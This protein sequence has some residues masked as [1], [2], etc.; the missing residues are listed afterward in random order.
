MCVIIICVFVCVFCGIGQ[1]LSSRIFAGWMTSCMICLDL[2][3]KIS[4]ASTQK[5]LSIKRNGRVNRPD[6]WRLPAMLGADFSD[7]R[8]CRC[9]SLFYLSRMS[10]RCQASSFFHDTFKYKH[11]ITPSFFVFSSLFGEDVRVCLVQRRAEHTHTTE[12]R[13]RYLF[14]P[15]NFSSFRLLIAQTLSDNFEQSSTIT[16]ANDGHIL[17]VSRRTTSTRSGNKKTEEKTSSSPCCVEND[18]TESW[19]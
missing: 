3:G 8:L 16:H 13:T 10:V 1:Q 17:C 4:F 18:R 7:F 9:F 15:M 11:I 5:I 19:E 2:S 12:D 6:G 14:L